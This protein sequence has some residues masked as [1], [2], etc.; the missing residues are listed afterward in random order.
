MGLNRISN[1]DV[2]ANGDLGF[3]IGSGQVPGVT[4]QGLDGGGLLVSSV[5]SDLWVGRELAAF[6]GTDELVYPTAGEQWTLESTSPNDTVGGTGTTFA[7]VTFMEE[8]TRLYT[9]NFI[10]LNGT[11]PVDLTSSDAYRPATV[12]SI[13]TG[14]LGENAGALLL[15][16]KSDGLFRG[17]IPAGAGAHPAG[18]FTVPNGFSWGIIGRFHDVPKDSDTRIRIRA[19]VGLGIGGGWF[20]FANFDAYQNPGVVVNPGFMLAIPQGAE[21]RATATSTNPNSNVRFT[22]FARL[23]ENTCITSAQVN[24]I[25]EAFKNQTSMSLYL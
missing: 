19:S 13:F 18:R 1:R 12:T 7:S 16:R 10:G 20:D 14:S 8:A 23:I 3:Y 15:K 25:S 4:N 17:G 11:T 6:G 24:A 5:A 9:S 2:A 22:F 21:F